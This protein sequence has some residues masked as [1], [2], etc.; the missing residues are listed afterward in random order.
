VS[1]LAWT[2]L[3]GAMAVIG[4][5]AAHLLSKPRF[6]R[7]PFTML[8]FLRAG[9]SHSHS[10]RRLRDLLILLL[11]CAVVVLIAILFAQPV[12]RVKAKP[13][14]QRVVMHL[15]LDDSMSMA[16]RDGGRSLFERMIDKALDHVRQSPD[17]TTFSIYGLASSRSSHGL[18][19]IE[20]IAAIRQLKVV[21]ASV[22]LS[23]FFSTLAQASRTA[24]PDSTVSAII[25][26]DFTPS[27]LRELEQVAAPVTVDEIHCE[28]VVPDKPAENTAIVAARVASLVGDTLSLDV[29]VAHCGSAQHPCALAAQLDGR[30]PLSKQEL[31][32]EPGQRKVV[33]LQVE[34]GPQPH[35]SDQPCLPIELSLSHGDGLVEDD[36]YRIAV[37]IPRTAQT[38]VVLVHRGQESFLFE[39]AMQA[40]AGSGSLER[41]KLTKVLQGQLTARDLDGADIVVF[42][43]LPTGPST[44]TGVLKAFAEKGGRLVFFTAGPPDLEPAKPLARDGLMA[45]QPQRWVQAVAYPEPRP[46]AGAPAGLDE[47]AAK[48][49]SNYRLDQVALKGYWL[50]RPAAQAQC[51]WRLADGEGLLYSVPCGHGLSTFVNTSIDDSLGLLAKSAAWVAF[52]R[53]LLGQTDQVQ[54]FCFSTGERPVLRIA[55]R[56]LQSVERKTRDERTSVPVEN[57]DGSKARAAAQGNV[58][59]LPPPAGIGWMK[60]TDDPTLY[61]GINLPAGET[62][63]TAPTQ[64]QIADMTQRVFVQHVGWAVPTNSPDP[65]E[66]VGIAHP[67][68]LQPT[69]SS[70]EQKPV[71]PFVAW[72]AMILLVLESAV[73]NRLK[74]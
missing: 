53:C 49:L 19:K 33:R 30:G 4:P 57:C 16:Y 40:L 39:T 67:T 26:S 31:T 21:P 12:L 45:A 66:T 22:R 60:T 13:H 74:R 61:A 10:R 20:T 72:A 27:A 25:L 50:C 6:R 3:F 47:R 17:D 18:S 32:L 73:A 56:G 68:S 9:Q 37:Y 70:L 36:T 23:D 46:C 69:A 48:S 29:T 65:R 51:L 14:A 15:A 8:R 1:F 71:W 52:C 7:V 35:K 41:L 59:L 24:A 28:P 62:D 2:F 43:S 38:N 54:Q 34:L 64:E 58:L 55:D 44:R 42:S 11:R 5:I 63:L